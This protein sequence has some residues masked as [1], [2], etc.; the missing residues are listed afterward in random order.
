[1]LKFYDRSHFCDSLFV[2]VIMLSEELST[3]SCDQ[4]CRIL[5][6][7]AMF[8][9]II[10]NIKLTKQSIPSSKKKFILQSK[11]SIRSQ[12]SFCSNKLSI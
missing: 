1:M 11:C 7:A 3:L 5:L 8:H 2:L 10:K 6:E 12:T 9:I 4:S